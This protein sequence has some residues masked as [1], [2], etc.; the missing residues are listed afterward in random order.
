MDMILD[1]DLL[2][3]EEDDRD[4]VRQT[5]SQRLQYMKVGLLCWL[6]F[7]IVNNLCQ[8]ELTKLLSKPIRPVGGRRF[9]SS[10]AGLPS[11]DQLAK[12]RQ[13]VNEPLVDT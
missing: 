5:K 6:F 2:E 1:E 10:R 7:V 3:D 9:V 8:G 11:A 12:G 4:D 13:V